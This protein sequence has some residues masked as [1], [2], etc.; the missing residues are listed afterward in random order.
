MVEGRDLAVTTD[1][2]P[3]PKRR[4]PPE[5]LAPAG[6]GRATSTGRSL[7]EI[8]AEPNPYWDDQGNRIMQDPEPYDC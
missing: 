2:T 7:A 3:D 5:Y 1:T 8:V 4:R 6:D